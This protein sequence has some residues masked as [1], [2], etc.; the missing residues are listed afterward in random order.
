[1][2]LKDKL[3]RLCYLWIGALFGMIVGGIL[4]GT[5]CYSNNRQSDQL[6]KSQAN[7]CRVIGTIPGPMRLAPDAAGKPRFAAS[8]PLTGWVCIYWRE[9]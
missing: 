5:C 2:N 7:E 4:I 1:M 8:P 6:S 9:S 3:E